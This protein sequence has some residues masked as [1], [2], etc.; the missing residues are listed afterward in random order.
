MSKK[1][2]TPTPKSKTK[3]LQ[4]LF[5][6]ILR[7]LQN[8]EDFQKNQSVIGADLAKMMK[9]ALKKDYPDKHAYDARRIAC[10]EACIHYDRLSQTAFQIENSKIYELYKQREINFTNALHKIERS[11]EQI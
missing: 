9:L 4:D 3:K 7:S 2:N 5:T 6:N 8:L 11:S 1:I 10:L